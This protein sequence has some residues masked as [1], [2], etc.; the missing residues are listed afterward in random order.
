MSKNENM[1]WT[2]YLQNIENPQMGRKVEIIAKTLPEAQRI[3]VK[4]AGEDKYKLYGFPKEYF[5]KD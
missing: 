1:S 3:A 4:Q 5:D 2:I